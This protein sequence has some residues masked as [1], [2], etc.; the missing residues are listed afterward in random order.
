MRCW[1][2]IRI[3]GL[4]LEIFDDTSRASMPVAE[5][6]AAEIQY[7]MRKL[8]QFSDRANERL[9]LNCGRLTKSQAMRLHAENVAQSQRTL[10]LTE[11]MAQSQPLGAMAEAYAEE[12]PASID[13]TTKR[14]VEHGFSVYQ[15][16]KFYSVKSKEI[17]NV[18]DFPMIE[19]G[20]IDKPKLDS[21]T[22]T[23]E[24]VKNIVIPE[25]AKGGSE[26]HGAEP[27]CYMDSKFM[28]EYG[29]PRRARKLVSHAWQTPFL[30]TLCNKHCL[31]QLSVLLV[32]LR[33][34]QFDAYS[35]MGVQ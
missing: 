9:A 11:N 5:G 8:S 18:N 1:Q 15:L 13:P 24:V 21:R 33:L 2:I 16:L 20:L 7:D 6:Q 12:F 35:F 4:Q 34:F 30:T 19:K 23:D 31:E 28:A 27:C 17:H 3:A 10:S 32:H 22:K 14:L 25:T 26:L 29:G